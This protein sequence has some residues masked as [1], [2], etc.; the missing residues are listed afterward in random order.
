MGRPTT[1]AVS[2][3]AQHRLAREGPQQKPRAGNGQT[4]ARA[5]LASASSTHIALTDAF[6]L[7]VRGDSVT[8]PHAVERVL[9][10]LALSH[11]PVGRARLAGCLWIDASDR[12]AAS[13][14]RTALWRLQR[15]AGPLVVVGDDPLTLARDIGVDLRQLMNLA[16]GLIDHPTE[17]L[18]ALVPTLIAHREVLPDWDDEWIVSDREHFR[19][20]RLEA[21]ER[22][23][24]AFLS[25]HE[26]SKALDAVLAATFAE[27]LRES[28]WRLLIE[29]RLAQGNGAE[30]L[31][32]YQDYR[33]HL[34][35]ELG[36][37]PSAAMDA[38][39]ER[40]LGACIALSP[41]ARRVP[42]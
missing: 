28:S 9:A 42:D 26:P 16:R 13:S 32:I 15:D 14:L 40:Y 39:V 20:L 36:L 5:T 2:A 30:A 11:G 33:D 3:D 29:I 7:T 8:V 31:R 19:L 17:V 23:A 12:L 1:A 21:L 35:L 34:D 37:H 38:L 25:R 18:L 22:A 27:P 6:D 10:Y 41:H 24:E 4:A